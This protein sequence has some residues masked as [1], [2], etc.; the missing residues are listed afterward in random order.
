MTSSN[1][2]KPFKV[3]LTKEHHAWLSAFNPLYLA[4]WENILN[5][6]EESA[7]AEAGVRRLL[8]SYDITVEPN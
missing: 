1:L 6:D 8:Q 5:T 2:S 7:L 4:N 3:K